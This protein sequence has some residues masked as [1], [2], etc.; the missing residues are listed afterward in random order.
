MGDLSKIQIKTPEQMIDFLSKIGVNFPMDVYNKLTTREKNV[1][2]K[3]VAGILTSLRSK[4][5]I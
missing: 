3:S 2:G 1:F 5:D 4:S